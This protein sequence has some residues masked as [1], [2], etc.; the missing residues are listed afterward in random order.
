[1]KVPV[2]FSAADIIVVPYT[3]SVGASGPI[4]NYAGYGVPVISSD[5]GYHMKETLGGSITLFESGNAD[6]LSE[7]IIM[8]LMNNLQRERLVKEQLEYAERETWALA[9]KR[10]LHHYWSILFG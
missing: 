7:K 10:T 5:V 8:L 2:Y 1:V 9:A 6:D 3:E 4:H